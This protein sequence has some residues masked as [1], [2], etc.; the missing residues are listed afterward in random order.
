MKAKRVRVR[1]VNRIQANTTEGKE[2]KEERKGREKERKRLAQAMA[3]A[4]TDSGHREQRRSWSRAC[5][6]A[7]MS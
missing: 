3:K 7:S 4:C 1:L 2:E 5:G 6:C